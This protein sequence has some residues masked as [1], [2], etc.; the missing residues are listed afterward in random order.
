M[1][2]FASRHPN[3]AAARERVERSFSKPAQTSHGS[4]TAGDD[5]LAPS[6]NSLQVLTQ[7]IVELTDSHF[8]LGVM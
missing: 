5:H 2:T 6:L 4:P 1:R 8:A 3:Q 7:T